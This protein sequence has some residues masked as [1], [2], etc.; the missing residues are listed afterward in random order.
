MGLKFP[1]LFMSTLPNIEE[2]KIREVDSKSINFFNLSVFQLME[3][4]GF[5][6]ARLAKYMMGGSCKNKSVQL[7]CGKGHNG[8]DGLV[9]LRHLHNWGARVSVTLSHPHEALSP[10]TKH[11]LSALKACTETT[12]ILT[13]PDLILDGL[14]GYGVKDVPRAPIPQLISEINHSAAPV[15]SIDIPTGMDTDSGDCHTHWVKANATLSFTGVKKG[16]LH[17]NASSVVGR[18]FMADIGFPLKLSSA[19]PLPTPAH[20]EEDSI[21]ELI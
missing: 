20:F 14:L 9:A 18:L 5:Q 12:E 3:L 8:G 4:A 15:L 7:Y 21:I 13:P 2:S 1:K 6:T 17:P 16:F 10:A 11:H 19:F